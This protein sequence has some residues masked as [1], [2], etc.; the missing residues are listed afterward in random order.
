MALPISKMQLM[1]P[2][3]FPSKVFQAPGPARG[4]MKPAI[5]HGTF[6][7]FHCFTRMPLW[8]MSKIGRITWAPEA[9][10]FI[11]VDEKSAVPVG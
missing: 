10:T 1:A 11:R 6:M 7:A 3:I 8:G 2:S 9:L 5:R 4:E